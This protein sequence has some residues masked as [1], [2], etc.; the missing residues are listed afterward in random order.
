MMTAAVSGR[1]EVGRIVR[2]LC[3]GDTAGS[4]HER[5]SGAKNAQLLCI[6]GSSP[7]QPSTPQLLRILEETIQKKVPKQLMNQPSPRDRERFRMTFSIPE[8]SADRLFQYR[9]KFV[10]HMLTSPMY[11]NSQLG[12]PWEA[13]TRKYKKIKVSKSTILNTSYHPSRR[14]SVA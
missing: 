11:A 2:Q 7:R 9:T 1:C 13:I 12:K 3:G 8:A 6:S 5:V 4:R 10:Q 14:K